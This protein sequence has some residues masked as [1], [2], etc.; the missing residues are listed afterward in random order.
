MKWNACK[1][2]RHR[3]Q[4]AIDGPPPSLCLPLKNSVVEAAV[5]LLLVEGLCFQTTQ[6]LNGQTGKFVPH[7]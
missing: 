6:V 2:L 7:L 3:Q 4:A 5:A 1:F